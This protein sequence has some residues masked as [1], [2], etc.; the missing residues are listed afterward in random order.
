MNLV[1]RRGFTLV[2]LAIVLVIVG[3]L[4]GLGSGMT[5][6]LSTAIKVRETRDT[7]DANVQAVTSWASAN[8]RIPA[9]TGF[10][11]FS[12]V[13]K[14]RQDSWGR[15]FTFLYYSSIARTS[16][17]KD[18]ICGRS[19]TPLTVTTIDPPATI[20]NVAYVILSSGDNPAPKEIKSTL[21]G[22]KITATANATGN[23]IVNPGAADSDI[24]RWVTLDELR[25]KVGCQ[26]APL[27]IVNNELP[28][29][30]VGG[31]YS[32]TIFPDGGVGNYQWCIQYTPGP[33]YPGGI[34]TLPASVM[35]ANCGVGAT[36]VTGPSVQLT[37]TPVS[38]PSGSYNLIVNVKDVGGNTAQKP[39]V[40]TINPN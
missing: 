20:K 19:S 38:A 36:Y 32:A 5:G 31:N 12:S 35:I 26:G 27:K 39:F 40:L 37:A 4:V 28:F 14:S 13:A 11:N 2:E 6:I 34:S 9:A 24:V 1:C 21:N 3:L 17:T 25:S 7:A 22:P 8:N 10:G 29:A 30:N 16:P 33:P 15:P 18:T 23:I